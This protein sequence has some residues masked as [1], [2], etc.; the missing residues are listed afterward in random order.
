MTD[1]RRKLI[2][3]GVMSL[4]GIGSLSALEA[5]FATSRGNFIVDLYPDKSPV[6]VTHFVDLAEGRR[7]WVD[8][9]TGSVRIGAFY[10]GRGVHRVVSTSTERYFETGAVTTAS[11]DPGY[12]FL[13]EFH[14]QADHQPYVLAMGN[15]GPNT[16]GTRIQITGS[17]AMPHRNGK[18]AVFGRVRE[19][20]GRSVVDA[21]LAAGVNGTSVQ[22]VA[23]RGKEPW[24]AMLE[25]SQS[26]LP[27]VSGVNGKLNVTR[28]VASELVFP[29]QP[30]SVFTAW[31]SSDLAGWTPHVRRFCDGSVSSPIP[32]A[33]LDDATAASRFYNLAV[34][35]YPGLPQPAGFSSLAGK[36]VTIHGDAIATIVYHFDHT[37]RSGHFE[38]LLSPGGMPFFSG[39]FSLDDSFPLKPTPWS[40]QFRVNTPGFGGSPWQLVKLGWDS[41][42][43][44]SASGRHATQV[45]DSSMNVIFSDHGNATATW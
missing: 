44:Q 26:Q 7:T 15:D 11:A 21:I 35:D 17:L 39:S 1:W 36:R 27:V 45:M 25:E 14:P 2:V 5:E 23:I 20:T 24:E 9:V 6:T 33:I 38:N 30:N 31:S 8:P 4:T 40:L 32:S 29:Q 34:V 12:G 16:N 10:E 3:W 19:G 22:S 13:D 42:T 18:H 28:G 41:G 37:G 43:I